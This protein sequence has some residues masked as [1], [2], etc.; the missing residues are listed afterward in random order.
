MDR[1]NAT[2]PVNVRKQTKP[3]TWEKYNSL[4]PLQRSA[5]DYNT[6]L[7]GS[8]IKDKQTA[9]DYEDLSPEAQE[10]MTPR[11]PRCSAMTVALTA[12]LEDGQDA[13]GHGLHRHQCRP[14]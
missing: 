8:V 4:T 1:L 5:V 6:A 9:K 11:L 10:G 7:A 12:T 3:L 13:D 14:R 2:K